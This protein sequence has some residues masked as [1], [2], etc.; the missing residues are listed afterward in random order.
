MI[1]RINQNWLKEEKLKQNVPLKF[2]NFFGREVVFAVHTLKKNKTKNCNFLATNSNHVALHNIYV[3]CF[4]FHLGIKSY[5]I[6]FGKKHPT[7]KKIVRKNVWRNHI[8]YTIVVCRLS[9]LCLHTNNKNRRHKKS[10]KIIRKNIR[11]SCLLVIKILCIV[12]FLDRNDL[13]SCSRCLL[14]LKIKFKSPHS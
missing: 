14:T 8:R 7:K 12:F 4:I 3:I 5:D 1:L 11:N 9:L 2:N 13:D 10:L 6:Y